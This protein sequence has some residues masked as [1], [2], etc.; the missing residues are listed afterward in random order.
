MEARLLQILRDWG[1]RPGE[2]C[3]VAV[4]GGPDSVALLDLLA[5]TRDSHGLDLLVVHV[6]HGIHPESALVADQVEALARAYQLRCITAHLGL[7][8]TA[9]ETVAREAR[10]AWL[11]DARRCEGADCIVTAHHADDQAETVLLRVL[12][13]SGPAGLAA[14]A[15][16][17]GRLLRPFLSF[18][19][20]EIAAY[21]QARSL[22]S[23]DDPANHDARHLRSWIRNVLF[24]II[25]ER[26]P[27]VDVSL[28]EVAGQA[29]ENRA[30]WDLVLDLLPGLEW[31]PEETGGSVAAT[32]LGRYDS[33]LGVTV[34]R[35]LG[36]RVGCRINRDQ[37]G[38]ALR[39]MREQESGSRLEIGNGWEIEIVFDRAHLV[40]RS[41]RTDPS[42]D[43]PFQVEGDAGDGAL[44]R[45]RLFWRRESAPFVHRRDDLTA[46]FIPGALAVRP[47]EPG[48][49]IHPLGGAGRRLVVKCL[50]E[51]KVPRRMREGWPMVLDQSG[52][53]VWVP[54][55]CRSNRLV[56]PAGAEALRVDAQV[57]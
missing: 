53:I 44:G 2:R 43:D 39:L 46:W 41:D 36:R 47:W 48:D 55:V 16:R 3:I 34:L 50:Q 23:W 19:R 57:I 17:S 49:R 8:P 11:E 13:G 52:E 24:P 9:T 10:Y 21:L 15:L 7:G 25:R 22:P 45:W 26:I 31:R 30:A 29:G 54:G 40:Q 14:M 38:R 33:A 18:S 32:V 51:A 12:H 35:A 1:P 56:P 42:F 37:A 20:Q 5:A 28:L 6:D 27:G 4:S